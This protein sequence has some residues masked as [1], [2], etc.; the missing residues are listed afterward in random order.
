[1]Q[2]DVLFEFRSRLLVWYAENGR[3]LPWRRRSISKYKLVVSEILLQRTR[4]EAVASFFNTFFSRYPSWKK[5]AAADEAEIGQVIRPIGL[6]KRRARTL[7]QLATVMAKRNGRF[8]RTRAEVEGSLPGVG[9]YIAN[10]IF[11]LCHGEPQPLLDGNM[12]RVLERVFG[13]RKRSDIRYDPYLQ[14]LAFQVVQCNDAKELNWAI[15]DLAATT[16]LPRKPRC[17]SC[18]LGSFCSKAALV[19]TT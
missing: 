2:Q 7:K 5:L 15:L 16:C 1:M 9:Q 6:W 17:S 4:A 8:P 10:S 3:N 19:L 12:A 11:L 14:A 18:P 13:P